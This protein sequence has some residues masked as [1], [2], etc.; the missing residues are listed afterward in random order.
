MCL[1]SVKKVAGIWLARRPSDFRPHLCRVSPSSD[2]QW[3]RKKR[4]LQHLVPQ[5]RVVLVPLVPARLP[6]GR[7]SISA[8]T[9]KTRGVACVPRVRD[10]GLV[11]R[12][13]S[14]SSSVCVDSV[15]SRQRDPSLLTVATNRSRIPTPIL[16]RKTHGKRIKPDQLIVWK[17]ERSGGSN[18]SEATPVGAGNEWPHGNDCNCSSGRCWKWHQQCK[19][20]RWRDR[21]RRQRK[22][23]VSAVEW[24][25]L[26]AQGPGGGTAIW[27]E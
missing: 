21:Q 23:A 16:L 27:K 22:D 10:G 11:V 19:A 1:V 7:Q 17:Y 3:P 8:D 9:P 14:S 25:G 5:V 26:P 18:T 12:P 6:E 4:A 24:G 13:R 15:R 2:R 20:A